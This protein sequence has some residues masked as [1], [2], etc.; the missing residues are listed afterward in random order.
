MLLAQNSDC[1]AAVLV[2]IPLEDGTAL[3]SLVEAQNETIRNANQTVL[4]TLSAVIEHRSTESGNHVLR[5][6]RFTQLLLPEDRYILDEMLKGNTD[7]SRRAE[8]LYRLQHRSGEP[9]WVIDR[10]R[11]HIGISDRSSGR[12]PH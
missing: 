12:L 7:N 11:I 1:I 9:I 8:C 10:C 4:D 6:R 5:I 3:R 2:D